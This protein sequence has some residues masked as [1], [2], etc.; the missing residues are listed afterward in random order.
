L[1]EKMNVEMLPFAAFAS[2]AVDQLQVSVILN[3][4]GNNRKYVK[5][6][7][8]G[9]M[10]LDLHRKLNKLMQEKKIYTESKLSLSEL[11]K[12]LDT[13]PNYLSQVINEKEGKS[14]YDYINTLRIEEFKR[15]ISKPENQKY[16][17]ES[18]SYECGFNSKSSFNKNFK[19]A[20]VQSPSA[21][22]QSLH[23]GDGYLLQVAN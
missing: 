6:G 14:F 15:L 19:K 17:I 9:E 20:T 4:T 3:E 10:A 23:T 11:A 5:S 18:L 7:L 12:Q 22:L 1:E 21:Y 13:L 2:N 8:T 16:T